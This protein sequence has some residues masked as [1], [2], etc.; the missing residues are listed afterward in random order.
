MCVSGIQNIDYDVLPI[1]GNKSLV[2]R[3]LIYRKNYDIIQR[4]NNSSIVDVYKNHM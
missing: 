1:D 3:G 2:T 4:L